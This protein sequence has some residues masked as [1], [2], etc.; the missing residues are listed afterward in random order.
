LV[1]T[2]NPL[3]GGPLRAQNAAQYRG[4]LSGN[5]LT[6]PT[7]GGGKK[8]GGG[9]SAAQALTIPGGEHLKAVGDLEAL[10]TGKRRRR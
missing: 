5:P 6:T 7:W 10:Y 8:S 4:I 2:I 3:L 9:M 1:L